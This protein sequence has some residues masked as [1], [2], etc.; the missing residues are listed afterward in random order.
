M[1]LL[2]GARFSV[3]RSLRN[4]NHTKSMY[5]TWYT[6]RLSDGIRPPPPPPPLL[7]L[8]YLLTAEKRVKYRF[9]VVQAQNM[10]AA[11]KRG[12]MIRIRE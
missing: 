8:S 5:L 9:S 1:L 3:K 11:L 4:E 10:R 6:F 2:C 7:P 12:E